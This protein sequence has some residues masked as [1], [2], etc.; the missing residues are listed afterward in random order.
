[1]LTQHLLTESFIRVRYAETDMM[2][3]VHHSAYV[4]YL[5]EGRSNL[6]RKHN[7]PVMMLEQMGYS[8][9]VTDLYVRYHASARYDDLL[10]LHTWLETLQSRGLSFGYEITNA[11][12]GEKLVTG[13]SK[14]ICI[15]RLGQVKVIPESWS[16]ILKSAMENHI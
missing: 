12:T 6:A 8:L 16:N 3:I 13:T 1:M 5:E 4:V 10:C 11:E 9:A 15:D 14:H 7:A 2:Q